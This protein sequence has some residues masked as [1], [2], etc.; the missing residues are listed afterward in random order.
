MGG[1]VEF[2]RV[3]SGGSLVV[4]LATPAQVVALGP[5]CSSGYS[6]RV[7][8]VAAINVDRWRGGAPGWSRS[9]DEYR[10]YVVDHEVGHWLGLGHASCPRAGAEAPVMMQQSKATAPC[11]NRVW[12]LPSERA[13]VARSLGVPIW[14]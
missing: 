9:L 2:R 6:C 3:S 13:T 14:S 8:R 11:V 10:H 4:A 1:S 7:G 5:P 12:P